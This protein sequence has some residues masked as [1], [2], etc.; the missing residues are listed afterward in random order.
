MPFNF[1]KGIISLDS[2]F[3]A[4]DLSIHSYLLVM[5]IEGDSLSAAAN[6]CIPV[7]LLKEMG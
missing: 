2:C 5:R 4:F 1:G 6:N 3:L 7:Y